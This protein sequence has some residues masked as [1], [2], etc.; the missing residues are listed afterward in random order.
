MNYYDERPMSEA[1][2][3]AAHERF[4]RRLDRRVELVPPDD[5]GELGGTDRRK[6]LSDP[7]I[8]SQPDRGEDE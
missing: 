3:R 5:L 2:M 6:D 1:Y 7:R 4:L 8:H